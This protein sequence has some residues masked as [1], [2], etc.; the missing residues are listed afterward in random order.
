MITVQSLERENINGGLDV[1]LG[2][3]PYHVHVEIQHS[4][5]NTI[6]DCNGA[7][8][9][10]VHVVTAAHCITNDKG[11]LYDPMT[12]KVEAGT[13]Y[14]KDEPLYRGFVKGIYLP[15]E[16]YRDHRIAHADI[17]V[18]KLDTSINFESS[19]GTIDR[20][21][22]AERNKT[23]EGSE[24]DFTG[25]G[26]ND[27]KHIE[28]PDGTFRIEGSSNERLHHGETLILSEDDCLHSISS[29]TVLNFDDQF[30][31]RMKQHSGDVYRG[32]CRG[33]SGGPLVVSDFGAKKKILS[34]AL[35]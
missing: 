35:R 27:V 33:D 13:I 6:A 5:T 14:L 9:D 25:F 31:A 34:F 2:D 8:L 28:K 3:Y 24:A 20:I 17:A 1:K 15:A 12:I 11:I 26:Y 4:T 10:D 22:L 32:A 7:I 29:K 16:F 23:Y 21:K 18:L 19:N 30:C